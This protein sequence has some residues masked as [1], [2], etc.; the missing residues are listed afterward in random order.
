[1]PAAA[2]QSYFDILSTVNVNDHVEQKNGLSY[3]SWAWA[4]SEFKKRYPY[5]FFE[6]LEREDGV[7][8]FTDGH[9]CW[10]KLRVTLVDGDVRHVQEESLPIMDFKNKSV[11]L[12]AVTSMDV[13]KAIKRCL[14]KCLAYFGLGMYIYAGEDLPQDNAE[15]S[16]LKAKIEAE[17]QRVTKGKTTEEKVALSNAVVKPI[18]GGSYRNVDD[19]SKLSALL[20]ELKKL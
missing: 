6:V 4:W 13:N 17:L 18:C 3:L 1:M 19:P 7:N 20:E 10:V 16:A 15:V 5:S 12:D 8:Y 2:K 9:T 14:V 11:P